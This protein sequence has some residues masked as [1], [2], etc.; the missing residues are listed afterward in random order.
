[1][2]LQIFITQS[3]KY[4]Y[5]L[6]YVQTDYYRAALVVLWTIQK[7]PILGHGDIF[8]A[9]IH[10]S[11]APSQHNT[12]HT[13]RALSWPRPSVW[14]VQ[15]HTYAQARTSMPI[16]VEYSSKRTDV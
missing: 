9:S 3:N 14:D 6:G 10:R 5:V 15:V 13:D 2:T 4:E 1:M 11:A 16:I 7:F 8:R 12:Q